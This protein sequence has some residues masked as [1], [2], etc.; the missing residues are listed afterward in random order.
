VVLVGVP[1]VCARITS[2]AASLTVTEQLAAS[3]G[4]VA[5]ISRSDAEILAMLVVKLAEFR[6]I[7]K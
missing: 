3:L 1:S 6:E 2:P 7:P 5:D 4:V